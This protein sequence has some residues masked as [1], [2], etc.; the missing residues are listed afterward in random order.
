MT[1]HSSASFPRP[2]DWQDFER[3]S[4]VLMECILNDL[5]TERNGRS[6][7]A[8]NGVDIFGRKN[9]KGIDWFGVQC[10]GKNSGWP[11]ISKVTEEELREEVKKSDNFKPK[12]STF[13]LLTTAP[14]DAAIQEVAR[15]ITEEREAEG[16]PLTVCVWGWETI[17]E[18]IA[19]HPEAMDAFHPDRS[20]H[21]KLILKG[22]ADTREMVQSVQLEVQS[23]T[24]MMQASID[25]NSA[26][27]EIVDKNL[28]EEIDGYRDLLKE[29][30]CSTA[31]TLL[32]NLKNRIWNT[33]SERV[34]FRIITNIAGSLLNLNRDSEAIPLFFEAVQYQPEDKT[35]QANRA[36]AYLLK[37]DFPEVIKVGLEILKNNPANFDAASFVIQACAHDKNISDPLTLLPKEVVDSSQVAISLIHFFR[38]REDR[39][40]KDLARKSLVSYP[41]N[42]HI[43]RAEAEAIL[44]DAIFANMF[45]LG[46]KSD[47]FISKSQI[48]EVVATLQPMW[49][50]EFKSENL[51][52]DAALPFNLVQAYRALED[53]ENALKIAEEAVQKFPSSPELKRQCAELYCENRRESDAAVLLEKIADNPDIFLCLQ[54]IKIRQNPKEVGE[55]LTSYDSSALSLEQQEK[56]TMLTIDALLM[57]Q[58]SDKERAIEIAEKFVEKNPESI[59]ALTTLASALKKSGD[60]EKAKITLIRAKELILPE[61]SFLDVYMLAKG[62]ES[63]SCFSEVVNLLRGR[64]DSRRDSP[65]L[66]TL[67]SALINSDER[68]AANTLLNEI[69]ESVSN[70]PSF[71]H[72]TTV[73]NVRRGDYA[74]AEKTAAE[75]FKLKPTNLTA[76]LDLLGIYITRDNPVKINALL[77]GDLNNLKGEPEEVMHLAALLVRYKHYEKAFKLAYETQLLNRDNSQV[78][79]SYLGLFLSAPPLK[80]EFDLK[81]IDSNTVFT[82]ESS[83]KE[84]RTFTIEENQDLRKYNDNAL[85]LDE[86]TSQKALNRQVGDKILLGNQEWVIKTIKHKYI[87]AFQEKLQNFGTRF[88]EEKGFQSFHI[89]EDDTSSKTILDKV[90]S[91]DDWNQAVIDI[92]KKNLLPLEAL[93]KFLKTDIVDVW[94]GLNQ[95]ECKFKVCVGNDAERKIAAD[96]IRKN[97]QAGCVVDA[98]TMHIIQVLKIEDAVTAVCGKMTTTESAVNV[99]RYRKERMASHKQPFMTIFYKDGEPFR[100]EVTME[101]I[102]NAQR[103]IDEELEWIKNNVTIVPAESDHRFSDE[104]LQFQELM[105]ISFL[106]PMLA[107]KNDDKLLLCEDLAYRHL[108]LKEGLSKAS[109]LQPVLM[110]AREE[111]IITPAEYQESI[112]KLIGFGHHFISIES[113]T[114]SYI[115]SLESFWEE[116]LSLTSKALFGTDAEVDSHFRVAIRFLNQ[117]WRGSASPDKIKRVTSVILSRIYFGDWRKNHSPEASEKIIK[118]FFGSVI[119][120]G[121]KEKIFDPSHFPVVDFAEYLKQWQQGHFVKL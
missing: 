98:L 92:Y 81:I 73:L 53:K 90:K 45:L 63:L 120:I 56:I 41:D 37:K 6:G 18:R 36:L 117:I 1:Q 70:R 46:Q 82:V 69:P 30:S 104:I 34:K 4:R 114:L 20:A 12:I 80:A 22:M 101:Q 54:A 11:D 78:Q 7:Q 106:D 79:L 71:L 118:D 38:V 16:R 88:S 62:F 35:A 39:A 24:E 77:G 49:D 110:V 26:S 85:S 59:F 5:T 29:G 64:V 13:I 86:I 102:K 93:K 3:N 121:L 17:S 103:Y 33:A 65:A 99:I 50:K 40:W 47:K 112:S 19:I 15:I 48:E 75:Y 21:S 31:L 8:Q 84:S 66:I 44:D 25:T 107:A 10:K 76:F 72:A 74:A 108:A 97:N 109:W 32:Q 60:I 94:S 14:N 68:K 105:G 87:H 2:L 23:Q 115:F 89:P 61:T 83:N 51:G 96:N 27:R 42:E 43:K 111:K 113:E 119:R 9:G 52:R 91:R 116:N 28:H 58:K 95:D 100:H 57:G 55:V 67:F